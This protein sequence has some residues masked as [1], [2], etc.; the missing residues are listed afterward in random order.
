MSDHLQ[1]VP[2]Y[3]G[4]SDI[5]YKKYHGSNMVFWSFYYGKCDITYKKVQ[6]YYG[7]CDIT[8]RKNHGI[9]IQ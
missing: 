9:N 4:K 3:Y 1:K 2:W 5:T 7:K 8:Y 6:L